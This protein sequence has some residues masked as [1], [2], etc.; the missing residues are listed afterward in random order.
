MTF[1]LEVGELIST[2]VVG[3]EL[4]WLLA[5]VTL[6][7]V[8]NGEARLHLIVTAS[9]KRLANV[10][11]LIGLNTVDRFVDDTKTQ[12]RAGGRRAIRIPSEQSVPSCF[13]RLILF[14]VRQHFDVQKLASSRHVQETIVRV[15]LAILD[16]S[17]V[18]VNVRRESAFDRHIYH[19]GSV[20]RINHASG[21]HS[22]Q[23]GG[24]EQMSLVSR[25][26]CKHVRRFTR[27]ISF[28]VG[29]Q[30]D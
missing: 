7:A 22:G 16:V 19:H 23:L 1:I 6:E 9:V 29:D 26:H 30:F 24:H 14:L 18:Q 21:H 5:R 28:L 20:G 25:Q 8:R 2:F 27:L 15:H 13:A 10:A 17:D 11:S 12:L 4:Q 3:R